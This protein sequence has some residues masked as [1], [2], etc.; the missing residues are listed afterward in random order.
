[1][2][3]KKKA[4]V[5]KS[6][7]KA[8]SI[9]VSF[10]ATELEMLRDIFG[11]VMPIALP[12]GEGEKA[13]IVMGEATIAEFLA[14]VTNRTKLEHGLWRKIVKACLNMNVVIGEKAPT[15]AVSAAHV[16]AM[17]VYNLED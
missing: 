9:D 5:K 6:N 10:T 13:G 3:A 1:M 15:F 2:A 4:T 17:H 11:V 14:A 12:V 7:V 8:K 16:P